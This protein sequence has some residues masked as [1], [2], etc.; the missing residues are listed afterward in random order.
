MSKWF[1][2]D[3]VL[4]AIMDSMIIYY[5]TINPHIKPCSRSR[6]YATLAPILTNHYQTRYRMNTPLEV[7]QIQYSNTEHRGGT[8]HRV[9]LND[10]N[11]DE[12]LMYCVNNFW[13]NREEL[14]RN[15]QHFSISLISCPFDSFDFDQNWIM[16]VMDV[17]YY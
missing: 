8:I 3:Q 13:N 10:D 11:V 15:K 4:Y 2:F 7:F 16:R 17:F 14:L 9:S 5:H 6:I 1:T 12:G